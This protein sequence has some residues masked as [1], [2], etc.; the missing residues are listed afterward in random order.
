MD[1]IDRLNDAT[2]RKWGFNEYSGTRYYN[3]RSANWLHL[4]D[5]LNL[6]YGMDAHIQ[7]SR[8]SKLEVLRRM[9]ELEGVKLVDGW[10]MPEPS[11]P[12]TDLEFEL[13][14]LL[15]RIKGEVMHMPILCE[16][17]DLRKLVMVE[18]SQAVYKHWDRI[19]DFVNRRGNGE[20]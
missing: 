19:L 10:D 20:K 5:D 2:G 3:I 6:I 18:A 8:E 12:L 13:F 16:A 11:E 17:V 4:Q 14:D 15:Y 1:I 7:G 9:A